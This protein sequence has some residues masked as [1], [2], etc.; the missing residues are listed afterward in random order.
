MESVFVGRHAKIRRAIIDKYVEILPGTAIGYD[1]EEDRKR[2]TVTESGVVVIQKGRVV[3][4]DKD[5]PRHGDRFVEHGA[6]Q[7]H[8]ALDPI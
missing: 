1:L 8:L 4:P 2:F 7:N 3:G 6:E 5:L